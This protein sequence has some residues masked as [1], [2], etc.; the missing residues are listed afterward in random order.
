MIAAGLPDGHIFQTKIPIWVNFGGSCKGRCW[1]I[2]WSFCLFFGHWLYFVAI[3]ESLWSFAI[4]SPVL[5]YCIEKNLAT[6]DDCS[7][8]EERN[9]K[10]I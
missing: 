3:W 2:L 1:Y 7:R 4:Y 8:M 10:E 6:L 5:V 9:G